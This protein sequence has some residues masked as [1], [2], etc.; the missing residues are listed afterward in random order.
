MPCINSTFFGEAGGNVALVDGDRVRVGSPGAPGCTMTGDAGS[1]CCAQTGR[2]S[3]AVRVLATIRPPRHTVTISAD[4]RLG[5]PLRRRDFISLESQSLNASPYHKAHRGSSA[6]RPGGSGRSLPTGGRLARIAYVAS[7]TTKRQKCLKH[8]H[9]GC[10]IPF[11]K[12]IR[13]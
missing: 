4:L 2:E 12:R 7:P 8:F 9:C 6:V 5:L 3:E 10:R 13:L 1:A 11:P